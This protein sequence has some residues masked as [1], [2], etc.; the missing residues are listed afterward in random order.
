MANGQTSTIIGLSA[1]VI[2]FGSVAWM[3]NNGFEKEKK[4]NRGGTR[5]KRARSIRK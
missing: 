2:F 4:N 1:V 5:R 3:V